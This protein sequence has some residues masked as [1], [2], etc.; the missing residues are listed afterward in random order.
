MKLSI[1]KP[2]GNIAEV[3]MSEGQPSLVALNNELL[4]FENYQ[5]KLIIRDSE[6]YDSFELFVGDYSIPV[7]YNSSIDCFETESDLIFGGCF[8]LACISVYIDDGEGEGKFFY[9]DFLR[10]AT[11]K[12]TAKQVEEMLEEIEEN[13]PYF[14][15]ICFSRNKKRSG[16]IKND[17][18]SI[19]N[20]LKI[21][22]EII[23]IYEETY[24]Y[25]FNH[26]KA[27]VEP[28]ATI[29]DVKAMRVVDQ[30]SLRWIACNPD[31]LIQMEKDTGVIINEQN[32]LPSKVK[33]YLSQY[34]YDVY[35]NRIVL[36]FLKNVIDYLENQIF[37]FNKQIVELA[38]IPESIV[39]QLPN[40]HELTGRCV[41]IYY[42]GII[43]RFS[44]RKSVLQEI[45]YRY[46]KIF[47]CPAE[48]VYGIPEFTNTFKQIYHYRL[49]YECMVKWF[50][51]G[52]YTFDHLNY[53]F[54][55]KT[56]SRIFEYFCLIKIQSAI[57]LCGYAFREANRIVY[58]PEDDLED[59]NNQYIFDG[60]GY[61]LT[62]L[63]E[64]YIWVN[65]LNDGINL[66]STGYNYIK[67]K[68]NDRWTPDFIIKICSSD[69]DY[70]YILDAKYSNASN[71][72]KRYIPDLVLK[73]GT[74][75]ASKDKFF[76]DIIGVG[77]V[78]P[79]SEDNINF[80]KKNAIGSQRQSLPKYFSFAI[81]GKRSG[82][83]F[84]KE[85]IRDLFKV[86]E[87]IEEE[88]E[89]VNIPQ[90]TILRVESST[91]DIVQ[92]N[93][94]IRT[95]LHDEE[96]EKKLLE[97]QTTEKLNIK[98]KQPVVIT[99]GKKCFYFGKGLC[100]CQKTRCTILDMAC[101]YYLPKNTKELL[102]KE[103]SCRNLISYTRRG[104]IQRV[105]CSI[106]GLP[107]CIGPEECKFCLKKNKSKR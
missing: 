86:V 98:D 58:D 28:V 59:I 96:A 46:G 70:Y 100:L 57:S 54:K 71:V 68:W 33:T 27:S 63:Y 75:I 73:Y 2:D 8:D 47:T 51:F 23:K 22:D 29:V 64:P 31:N 76:S 37:G 44:E 38:D 26:K 53:L 84:L 5:Y 13:F 25:F 11:T 65:K 62:L 83:I 50:E 19:W 60:N 88:K 4:F 6:N 52:D 55:L 97:V 1:V 101:E 56:L 40:T 93:G 104:K 16:L 45:Y 7:H 42:K 61:E 87:T 18:R 77:A 89:S 95:T 67:C 105:E 72:K 17:V 30:E 10:I 49:C 94:M 85:R 36:G 79:G 41:Y 24:G 91:N 99:S 69:R 21:V 90:E 103:D 35:E 74:Q 81:V 92:Q 32:Y 39:A 34:C 9:T 43:Q 82:D 15:E 12:Q 106:S 48:S 14:L 80:F 78:Y 102:T 107:G 66:Y 3:L 20:T